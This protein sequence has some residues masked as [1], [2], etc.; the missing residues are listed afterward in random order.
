[1]S[2]IESVAS[3]GCTQRPPTYQV[4][5]LSN[6]DLLQHFFLFEPCHDI[7]GYIHGRKA[8]LADRCPVVEQV[9]LCD[10]TQGD[11]L[12]KAADERYMNHP[13]SRGVGVWARFRDSPRKPDDAGS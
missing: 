7:F 1:M 2:L 8:A 12:L 4:A 13:A 9:A 10:F 11:W 3:W 5:L 6:G